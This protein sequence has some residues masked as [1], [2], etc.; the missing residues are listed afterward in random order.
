MNRRRFADK[1]LESSEDDESWEPAEKQA[2]TLESENE[3][4]ENSLGRFIR[5]LDV[6]KTYSKKFKSE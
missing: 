4:S 5:I 1:N 6:A 3:P 2:K